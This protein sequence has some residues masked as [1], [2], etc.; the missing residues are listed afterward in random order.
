MSL[1]VEKN[2]KQKKKWL[3]LKV[4]NLQKYY[5]EILA[6]FKQRLDAVVNP[7]RI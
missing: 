5:N 7:V 4:E 6:S 1:R 3:A 2:Y